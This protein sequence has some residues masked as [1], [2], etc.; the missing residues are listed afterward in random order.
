[1]SLLYSLFNVIE[2]GEKFQGYMAMIIYIQHTDTSYESVNFDDPIS[3]LSYFKKI[4]QSYS[5][6]SEEEVDQT[7]KKLMWAFKLRTE[8]GSRKS[9]EVQ[10]QHIMRSA[11]EKI[12]NAF[13]ELNRDS[14]PLTAGVVVNVIGEAMNS[15]VLLMG[16]CLLEEYHSSKLPVD[17]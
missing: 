1:V 11:A 14:F 4:Y 10:A 9:G 16:D 5:R 13:R 7:F 8:N 3:T 17:S 2:N 6:D 15:L 12:H